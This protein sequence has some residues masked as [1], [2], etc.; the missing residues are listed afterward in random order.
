MY[1]ERIE[2]KTGYILKIP[3]PKVRAGNNSVEIFDNDPEKTTGLRR[4]IE[5]LGTQTPEFVNRPERREKIFDWVRLFTQRAKEINQVNAKEEVRGRGVKVAWA[6]E[7]GKLR[8]DISVRGPFPPSLE[9]L[10]NTPESLDALTL[11][12]EQNEES[13][14]L[15]DLILLQQLKEA[16]MLPAITRDE[17]VT[18]FSLT[19][20]IQRKTGDPQILFDAMENI[21][22]DIP[23]NEERM[24]LCRV[25]TGQE[26]PE[27]ADGLRDQF[28]SQLI[29]N[30]ERTEWPYEEVM[31][32]KMLG[33]IQIPDATYK[34]TEQFLCG[35]RGRDTDGQVERERLRVILKILEGNEI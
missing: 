9:Y 29:I 20:R 6:I 10:R 30:L 16:R 13:H 34:R 35:F 3:V 15:T 26:N 12:Y 21:R 18:T 22:M 17:K 4:V 31:L 19:A 14:S 33:E 27:G 24:S 2:G 28:I 11:A 5:I 23:V 1:F 7:E 25:L 8:I 32:L